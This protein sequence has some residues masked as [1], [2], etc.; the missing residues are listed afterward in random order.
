[1]IGG[2]FITLEGG[3]GAGKSTQVRRLAEALSSHADE[4]V[5][6]REPGGAPG[7]EAIRAIL[8]DGDVDRW[9]AVTE[10]LLHFAARRDHLAATILPA[11]ERGACVICDRFAD[12]TMAYQ[13]IVQGAGPDIVDRLYAIAVGDL[14]PD[15]TLVLD[16][17]VETGLARAAE[18]G[19]ADRY[20]RMG[21]A[22]HERLRQAFLDIVA[23]NP[24]RCRLID[25]TGSEDDVAALILGEVA[26]K[27]DLP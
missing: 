19:G 14:R 24:D 3:E 18:R 12:S 23:D 5:T 13:G 7:A 22:Y 11:L 1:M 8:V 15:L 21:P 9:D 2:R 4:I 25:A 16:L 26:A 20:E 6:T 27:F 17:P 10:A